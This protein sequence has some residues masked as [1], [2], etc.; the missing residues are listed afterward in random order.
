MAN[1][2][3]LDVL[4]NLRRR[5][6]FFLGPV[7]RVGGRAF[8]A[9]LQRSPWRPPV[10]RRIGTQGPFKMNPHFA[11]L[12]LEGWSSGQNAG[13]ERCIELARGARCVFDIGAHVGFVT[14]PLS[15]NISDDGIVYSFEPGRANL[16]MLR[17]H[18]AMNK[19][20]NVVIVDALLGQS[21]G[22][23]IDFHEVLEPSGMNSIALKRAGLDYST[24]QKLVTTLDTFCAAND[25]DPSL[26]KIDVEGSELAVLSGAR[27]TLQKSAPALMLSV[28]PAELK[29]LGHEV[30]DV[31]VLLRDAGYSFFDVE[32]QPID[33]LMKGENVAMHGSRSA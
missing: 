15:R 12:D 27:K 32:M 21:D 29:M 31:E 33:S 3:A 6:D 14:L 17:E 22:K 30:A 1:T 13:F 10:Q 19:V 26:M 7:W 25:L 9:L 23:L 24:E 11:F 20:T 16:G 2:T 8:R 4:R 18:L 5:T 28:H